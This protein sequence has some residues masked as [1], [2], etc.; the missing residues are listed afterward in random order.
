MGGKRVEYEYKGKIWNPAN[1]A[2]HSGFSYHWAFRK[3][4]SVINGGLKMADVLKMEKDNTPSD[5]FIG[6]TGIKYTVDYIMSRCPGVTEKTALQRI[7]YARRGQKNE[8]SLL[9]FPKANDDYKKPYKG[10][11]IKEIFETPEQRKKMDEIEK[12]VLNNQDTI[13][14]YYPPLF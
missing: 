8:S 5:V 2:E 4:K 10:P 9:D 14:K 3:L 7:Q 1:L 13:D 6:A 11:G 12:I